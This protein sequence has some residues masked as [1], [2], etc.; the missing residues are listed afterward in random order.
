MS[1]SEGKIDEYNDE[2]LNEEEISRKVVDRWIEYTRKNSS[3]KLYTTFSRHEIGKRKT[4]YSLRQHIADQQNFGHLVV[5]SKNNIKMLMK[6]FEKIVAGT[7]RRGKEMADQKK[8]QHN[9]L[10]KSSQSNSLPPGALNR[11]VS[12]IRKKTKQD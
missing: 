7:E 4:I 12:V 10:S 2:A 3:R 6:D 5:L 8:N 1:L 9:S 11:S